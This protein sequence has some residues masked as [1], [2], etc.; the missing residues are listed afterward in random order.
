MIADTCFFFMFVVPISFNLDIDGLLSFEH[1]FGINFAS[2]LINRSESLSYSSNHGFEPD[3]VECIQNDVTHGI[4][5]P[6]VNW[7]RWVMCFWWKED[8]LQKG[9]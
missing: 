1:L 9:K 4:E 6:D 5:D 2:F 8:E 3:K 7:N